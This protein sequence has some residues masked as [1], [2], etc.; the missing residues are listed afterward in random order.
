M[1]KDN[2]KHIIVFRA[3][4]LENQLRPHRKSDCSGDS[5]L[6]DWYVKM[7]FVA[8]PMDGIVRIV[9]PG[10]PHHIP[11]RGNRRQESFLKMM[12]I[13]NIFHSCLHPV[14]SMAWRYG[15]IIK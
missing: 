13:E 6:N 11:Q 3:Q 1:Q 14:V 15:L 7:H 9:V 4:I 10:L 8:L 12:T 2:G 5:I